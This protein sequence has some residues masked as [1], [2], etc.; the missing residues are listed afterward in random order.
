LQ[1]T[2]WYYTGRQY[3]LQGDGCVFDM[4]AMLAAF[5]VVFAWDTLLFIFIGVAI[6]VSVGAIPGLAHNLPMALVLPMAFFL[7]FHQTMGLLVGTYKG[8]TY[9]GSITA[10]SFGTPGTPGSAATVTD[11]YALT[12][13]GKG[14]K[15]LLM[16]LYS[17]VTGD[18]FSDLVL[19]FVAVPIG[20][21][22]PRFGPA[23][24][25]ALYFLSLSLVVVFSTEDPGR[26]IL[27][28]GIG[29]FLASI[30]RDIITGSIRLTFGLRELEAGIPLVPLLMG[31][32]AMPEI[33]NQIHTVLAKPELAGRLGEKAKEFREK[34]KEESLTWREFIGCWRGLAIGSV[35]GTFLG[36]LP[37]PGATLAAYTAHSTTKRFSKDQDYG[38]GSLEGVAAAEAGNNATCGATFIPLLTFGIPGS[39]IAALFMAALMMEGIPL[40]PRVIV[41]HT[42]TIYTLFLLLLLANPFNLLVGKL[43]IPVYSKLAQMPATIIW[44]TIAVV[45]VLGTYAYST[46]PFDIT[47]AI[48]A[49]LLGYFMMWYR[50]PIGPLI[51]AYLVAPLFEASLRRGI[52]L[53]RGDWTYFFQSSISMTI[54]VITIAAVVF[55]IRGRNKPGPGEG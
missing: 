53:S 19:M 40:G 8:G 20:L 45:L 33:I 52:I 54:W 14:I 23:E 25:T 30:G 41:D 26:G 13:K 3:G 35:L 36:A 39:S 22:A 7:P 4:E 21:F 32:F 11:G 9:G 15:A 28:A 24:L 18:M 48:A 46:R 51:L 12:R 10:I 44:P 31:L 17:S 29:F 27:S 49:G 5:T 43:L 47:I 38:V 1:N 55:F 50:I 37:G 6:G 42:V 16:G 2:I 34:V